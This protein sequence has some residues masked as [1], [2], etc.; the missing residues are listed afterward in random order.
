MMR[1]TAPIRQPMIAILESPPHSIRKRFWRAPRFSLKSLLGLMTC[2]AVGIVGW[3]KF[4]YVHPAHR[5]MAYEKAPFTRGT[6]IQ[7]GPNLIGIKL[8]TR[9]DR[10]GSLVS[11]D[12]RGNVIKNAK[13]TNALELKSCAP[14]LD[15][16]QIQL[17]TPPELL[18]ITEVRVFDHGTRQW[19]YELSDRYGWRAVSRNTIQIYG[20]GQHIPEQ[21]DV[22]FRLFSHSTN[23][24][25]V[26][27]KPVAGSECRLP[28]GSLKVHSIR[29]G[30][31]GGDSRR[32]YDHFLSQE[33]TT[34]LLTAKLGPDDI[35]SYHRIF[36]ELASGERLAHDFMVASTQPISYSQR[37]F[38]LCD[39]AEI[40]KFEIR[41]NRERE[42]FF[43][44]GVELPKRSAAA[45]AFP[46]K[47]I[48]P[49]SGQEVDMIVPEFRPLLIRQEAKRGCFLN[50]RGSDARGMLLN[51]SSELLHSDDAVTL[52]QKRVGIAVSPQVKL[53]LAPGV[54]PTRITGGKSG[55]GGG[56]G[57]NFGSFQEHPY[58]LDQVQQIELV[59]PPPAK[60]AVINTQ[61]ATQ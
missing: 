43:Y 37:I 40:L 33:G 3:Q 36:A 12:G 51:V 28:K 11:T 48:I 21:L 23:D 53:R 30:N 27:L 29:S 7:V 17:T 57:L 10:D 44:E 60:P 25:V 8:I 15:V 6:S 46:P 45:F 55:G 14:W 24:S 20:I 1:Q 26:V 19:L 2:V 52:I 49:V 41:P 22:W 59:L 9:N 13:P 5:V 4:F 16:V 56:S 31:W 18:D 34:C 58:P 61:P 32:N 50:L 38:W 42:R 39:P 54:Q 35:T 47:A